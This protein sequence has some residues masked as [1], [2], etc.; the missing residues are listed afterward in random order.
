MIAVEFFYDF[1]S[2]YSYLASTRVE[3]VARRAGA[4]VR[5]RPFLLGGVFKATGNHP[6]GEVPAKARYLLVDLHRWAERYAVPFRWPSTFPI[7][8]LLA[9]RSALVAEKHGKLVPFTHAVFRAI[10]EQDLDVARPEVVARIADG[11]G[12]AGEAVASEAERMREALKAQTQEAVD[13][14]AFG[15]PSFFVGEELFVGNDRLDFVEEALAR[16]RGG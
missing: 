6:P 11:V 14:G 1:A 8:S 10:Y 5:F 13:R 9:L 16:S 12:L 15:A 2:P 7:P 3:E 4:A